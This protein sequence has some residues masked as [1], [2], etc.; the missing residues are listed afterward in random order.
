[1]YYVYILKSEKCQSY[2]VGFSSDPSRRLI[3]HNTAKKGY[4]VRCRPWYLVW[5]EAYDDKNEAMAAEKR[6]K[7]WKSRIL[8]EQ[9]ISGDI[10]LT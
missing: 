9:L 4:T 7:K 6:I 5:S 8:I 10:D 1:M 2:Y 3:F